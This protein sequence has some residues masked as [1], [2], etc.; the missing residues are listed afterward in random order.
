MAEYLLP[1][2]EN[3]T[4]EEQ[5]NIFSI[6]NRMVEINYNF[7]TNN[8]KEMCRCGEEETMK[9]IYIC[10]YQSE[11]NETN[12]PNF[13][14]IFEENV[15]QQKEVNKIFQKK[16]QK[17]NKITEEIQTNAILSKDPL[18]FYHNSAVME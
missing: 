4:I 3:I 5:R 15:I 12:K 14:E 1:G 10:D 8:K 17:R 11:N 13:E 18:C 9:H 7:P 6:R 2:Y 16:F